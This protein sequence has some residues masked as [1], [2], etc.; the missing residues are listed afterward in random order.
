MIGQHHLWYAKYNLYIHHPPFFKLSKNIKLKIHW[1]N[2]L[3]TES[4]VII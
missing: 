2:L 4:N 1:R 3:F